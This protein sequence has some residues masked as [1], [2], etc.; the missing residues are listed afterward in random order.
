MT[1]RGS[2]ALLVALII[3]P[4]AHAD[5]WLETL[6]LACARLPSRAPPSAAYQ[7]GV[8][9]RGNPVIPADLPETPAITIEGVDIPLEIDLAAL[10]GEELPAGA[11][12]EPVL[13]MLRIDGSS[14]TLDGQPLAPDASDGLRAL[15]VEKGLLVPAP[16]RKPGTR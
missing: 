4:P 11:V 5:P 14:V 10:L 1:I 2:S 6:A 3:I 9:V 12:L 15:C 13:G 8:D 7:P 16:G